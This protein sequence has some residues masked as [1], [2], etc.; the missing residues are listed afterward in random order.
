MSMM[1]TWKQISLEDRK[2]PNVLSEQ[3][4]LYE[5]AFGA[6]VHQKD[7]YISIKNAHYKISYKAQQNVSHL[8]DEQKKEWACEYLNPLFKRYEG[9]DGA[10][11]LFKVVEADRKIVKRIK[12][13][14]AYQE[15]LAITLVVS[16]PETTYSPNQAKLLADYW[17]LYGEKLNEFSVYGGFDQDVWCFGRALYLPA[18]GP[19]PTWDN[20][21]RRLNDPKAFAAWIYGV[22]SKRYKGRQVLWF[23]G[24]G[25]DGKSYIQKII[26]ECLFPDVARPMATSSFGE[27]GSRFIGSVFEGKVLAY[28]DDCNYV[29]AL[30]SEEVKRLSAGEQGN[31]SLIE[32]K[33]RG[34]YDGQLETR[35][36][37]NSNNAPEIDAERS[38]LSRLLYIYIEP[39]D[40]IP[41]P[42]IGVKFRRELP[43]FLEYGRTCYEEICVKNA[44]LQQ[45]EKALE[46]IQGLVDDSQQQYESIF[47]ESF[48]L[49]K[50]SYVACSQVQRVL[51]KEIGGKWNTSLSGRFYD[52]LERT[53]SIVR[54]KRSIGGKP[55][56]VVPSIRLHIQ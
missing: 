5:Q 9:E 40:E 51:K 54:E 22:A 45:S 34:A 32:H 48:K 30:M 12:D 2:N 6:S 28:W 11:E 1:L 49:D 44:E 20:Y 16:N 4:H 33:G 53:H 29:R 18:E 35:M 31:K 19:M 14:R 10:Y 55:T 8:S 23:H 37:I 25:N 26:A 50:H 3:M 15:Q 42:D 36:W 41:D 46:Q 21:L 24:A 38:V 13:R 39:M 43:A 52:W 27:G 56:K 47:N 17:L 7:D